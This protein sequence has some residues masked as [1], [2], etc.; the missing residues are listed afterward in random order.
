MQF[1][2][3]KPTEV[4]FYLLSA[5]N[6]LW[7]VEVIDFHSQLRWVHLD[8]P[9]FPGVAVDTM[10]NKSEWAGPIPSAPGMAAKLRL[11]SRNS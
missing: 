1:T 7:V 11:W 10:S 9:V 8:N 4:G 6:R 3:E 2:T 5:E